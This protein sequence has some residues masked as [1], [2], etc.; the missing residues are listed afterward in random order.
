MGD[1]PIYSVNEVIACLDLLHGQT[2]RIACA[3][4]LEFEGDQICHLPRSEHHPDYGS[5][6]WAN[7]DEA[8]LGRDRVG[9]RPFVGRHVVVE[10]TVDRHELGHLGLWP[11]GVVVRAIAK[12]KRR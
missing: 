1:D 11:G 2:L 9:L 7:F 5:Y 10:A 3:L 8:T 12:A 6:L 4:V